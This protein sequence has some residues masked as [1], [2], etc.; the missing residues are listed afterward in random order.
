VPAIASA[1][2]VGAVA[3]I[4][5]AWRILPYESTD[6]AFIE[7]HVHADGPASGRVA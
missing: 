1:L 7:G 2:V 5:Y 3:L 4:Y 6:D